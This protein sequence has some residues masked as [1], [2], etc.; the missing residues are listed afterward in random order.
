MLRVSGDFAGPRKT[1]KK[2]SYLSSTK[3]E[4]LFLNY[5]V[6]II[7]ENYITLLLKYRIALTKVPGV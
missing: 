2:K 7:I 5:L 3:K 4:Y 6:I 1:D